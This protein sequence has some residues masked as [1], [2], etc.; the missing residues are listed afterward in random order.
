MTTDP[1]THAAELRHELRELA[2]WLDDLAAAL[3]DRKGVWYTPAELRQWV[4]QQAARCKARAFLTRQAI[5]ENPGQSFTAPAAAV[6]DHIAG[7]CEFCPVGGGG[8]AVCRSDFA[9]LT[10]EQLDRARI[11]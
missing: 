6:A 1:T 2:A 10:T 7:S 9:A 3:D 8:C 4:S 11:D 5:G